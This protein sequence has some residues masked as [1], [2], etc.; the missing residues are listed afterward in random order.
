MTRFLYLAGLLQFCCSQT[1]LAQKPEPAPLYLSNYTFSSGQPEIG[2]VQT[3][4][5]EKIKT[6][7]LLGAGAAYLRVKANRLELQPKK[8][9]TATPWIDAVVQV[10]TTNANYTDTF[11]IVRDNFIR[12][13]VIAHR[14]AFKNTGVAEN[15]V[16]SL[17]QAIRM[18][19]AGSEFDVHLSSDGVPVISHDPRI[20][21]YTIAE[22]PVAVLTAIKLSHG[23]QLP[24]LETFLKGGLD[25]NKTKLILEIKASSA[26]KANSILLTQKVVALVEQLQAQAW[27][28]YISFDYDVCK[29]VMR[30]APYAKVAYLNGDKTPEALAAEKFYGLDYHYSVLQKNSSWIADAKKSGI[31]VNVWTVNDKAMMQDL[32]QQ[33]VDFITTNEP[34]LMLQLVGNKPL[35]AA[36]QR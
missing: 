31:T 12:N 20:G 35:A 14:G 26:G 9:D 36:S 2:M 15:S 32:L 19:C 33:G 10:R 6:I 3:T 22:T 23:E 13:K 7:K 8:L 28:D 27:I 21:G 25:Q 5:G 29:E 11:R 34:E 24:T 17:Q 4:T 16:A 30:L 18:G 1:V